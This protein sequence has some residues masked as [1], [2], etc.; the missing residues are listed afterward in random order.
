M[1][2]KTYVTSDLHLGHKLVATLRGFATVEEH[3][4]A[5]GSNILDTIGSGGTLWILGDLLFNRGTKLCELQ[6]LF[7]NFKHAGI[8]PKVVLGNH[9]NFTAKA[10]DELGVQKVYGA[11]YGKRGILFTHIPVHPG[12]KDRFTMNV[13]GHLHSARLDDPW[14]FNACLEQNNLRPF[15]MEEVYARIPKQEEKEDVETTVTTV[16]Y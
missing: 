4:E 13:H 7:M 5:I 1:K 12:Q 16:Y 8:L 10:L 6:N 2:S 11:A 14:Y 15:D 9:D 3:D